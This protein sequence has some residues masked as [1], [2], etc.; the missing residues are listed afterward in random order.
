MAP[1]YGEA[2][3][4]YI[5]YTTGVVPNE[6][7]ATAYVSGL[8][9]NPTFSGNVIIE[10]NATINGNLNVSG[11]IN[12]SGVTISGITGLFDDG[13]VSLPSIAFASDPDTGIYS[14]GADQL[15]ISTNGTQR[16]AI[17]SSGRLGVGNTSP[18]SFDT[19]ANNLVVGTGAGDNGITIYGGSSTG[20]YGSIFFADGTSVSGAKK[21]GQIR[22][23][24][25]NEVMSFYTNELERLRI[26]LSGNV[27]I[28]T[29]SPN[30][31]LHVL[32]AGQTT[33]NITDAGSRNAFL[34]VSDSG[35][36]AGSG[37]GILF[38]N[39]QGDNANSVGF[40]AIK[41]FLTSGTSNTTGDLA[42]S[43][44]NAVGDT[45]L[46]ER[47]RITSG[48][49][50]G[51]GT[52]SP[53][54]KLDVQVGSTSGYGRIKLASNST[55][56]ATIEAVRSSTDSTSVNAF[57]ATTGDGNCFN[58]NYG[59]GAYFK[60]NV[61]IGVQNPSEKLE[62]YGNARFKA[63]DG[64]H[65]IELYPDVGGLGY[66]RILSFNRTSSA[67]EDLSFGANDFIVTS[68]ATSE[69]LRVDSSGRLLVGTS[70]DSGG[71]LLQVNGDR[72]RIAT[73]KT[74]ASA[75]DTGTTGEICW[76]ASYIY[77]C[78]A[79]NTW[80]RTAIATW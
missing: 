31:G 37:G 15:A 65:G 62:V 2:R 78:T 12:A 63:T 28:G 72:V 77:V 38:A 14:P 4:D 54:A 56:S 51:I 20:D 46:S 6:G 58:V 53:Q 3:V 39:T 70:S 44:R 43:T 47:L 40:A 42:F 9:N 17:D 30:A 69:S 8:I 71:A 79:T 50:V 35:S 34:K 57:E 76:D 75:S 73:A 7:N 18:G 24:Q 52:S 5:T 1:Q 29:S 27:G 19:E 60:G 26:D 68:G 48:G 55:V 16:L 11:D 74:P 33:A 25:N 10:G 67:Y 49:N 36:V 66:Q 23:E 59:G 32:G 80:K 41:G 13:T 45:A 61:G 22:Y 21:K 64:S